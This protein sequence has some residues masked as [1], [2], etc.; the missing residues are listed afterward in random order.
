MPRYTRV[1]FPGRFQPV[2]KG[3]VAAIKW[4]LGIAAEI[5]IGVTAAQFNYTPENPFTAGERLTMLKLALSDMWN[6]LYVVPLDNVPDNSLWLCHVATRV[7]S[8]EA[9]ATN[10]SF[11][12]LL[13]RARSLHVVNPP[14]YERERISG[15]RLRELM[16]R[17]DEWKELVPERVAAYLEEIGGPKRVRRILDSEKVVIPRY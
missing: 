16:V 4:L 17:G 6:K 10:N 13:A 12:E 14:L 3:H 15:T 8:F 9:V 1:F 11:V 2:H 5:I 7:P